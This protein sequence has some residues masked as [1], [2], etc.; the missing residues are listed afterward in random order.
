MKKMMKA[1]AV[2]AALVMAFSLTGCAFEDENED[3]NKTGFVQNLFAIAENGD[4]G[5]ITL[6]AVYS[7]EIPEDGIVR[8]PDEVECIRSSA[9]Y[10]CTN[11]K[12]V[13]IPAN[14]TIIESSAFMDCTALN[15][16]TFAAGSK[17]NF[18]GSYAFS[19]CPELKTIE[20]P[21]GVTEI[22]DYA[23]G[24]GGQ[25]VLDNAT[26][27]L[28]VEYIGELA[29]CNT[30]EI[31]YKGTKAD[32]DKIQKGGANPGLQVGAKIIHCTDGDIDI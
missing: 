10:G 15:T 29:F 28:S 30:K 2:I 1:A 22:F 18:I 9:F 11:L 23:F 5:V 24:N 19:Y 25:T 17:L 8:I 3:K 32:W 13:I 31:T 4:D 26:V 7:S 12:E 20:I 14:V 27:P 21:D 6:F 16:V